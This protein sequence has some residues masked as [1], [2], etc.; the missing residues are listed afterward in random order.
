[1]THHR[2]RHIHIDWR[3]YVTRRVLVV[4]AISIIGYIL[5]Y[6]AHMHFAGKGGELLVGA[7]LGH[8]LLE[9]EG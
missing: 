8:C 7:V 3:K 1:M 6:I 4:T 2:P 9:V 5:D